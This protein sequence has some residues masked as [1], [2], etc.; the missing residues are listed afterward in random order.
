MCI[1]FSLG[2]LATYK[3]MSEGLSDQNSWVYIVHRRAQNPPA[4]QIKTRSTG[5]PQSFGECFSVQLAFLA[6]TFQAENSEHHDQSVGRNLR[7]A[8]GNRTSVKETRQHT[9]HRGF[10]RASRHVDD[11][12]QCHGPNI[13]PKRFVSRPFVP[14]N[15]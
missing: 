9:G 1:S 13:A 6:Y 3:V 8:T 7:L 5:T 12:E 15:L 14:S 4:F 2:L 10:V 11:N